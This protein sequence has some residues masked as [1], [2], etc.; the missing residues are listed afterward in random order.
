MRRCSARADS[1]IEPIE[2]LDTELHAIT[3]QLPAER[4]L[5]D[6][7]TGFIVLHGEV[8]G[9]APVQMATGGVEETVPFTF[10]QAPLGTDITNLQQT[11]SQQAETATYG[12]RAELASMVR[13][14]SEEVSQRTLTLIEAV[15]TLTACE[16]AEHARRRRA[17]GDGRVSA[18]GARQLADASTPPRE[19]KQTQ[20]S[21]KRGSP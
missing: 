4:A 8:S 12:T 16:I 1:S 19:L 5:I 13:E 10:S 17:G 6:D 15:G 20:S 2:E 21:C 11:L 9:W 3:E 7:S 18:P 14:V